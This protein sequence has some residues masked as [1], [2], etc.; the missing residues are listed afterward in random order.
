M[1]FEVLFEVR[2]NL[3]HSVI[4]WWF[5]ILYSGDKSNTIL[6]IPLP[7]NADAS[8][9]FAHSS[10]SDPSLPCPNNQTTTLMHYM[11]TAVPD[12][13]LFCL[14]K[15]FQVSESLALFICSGRYSEQFECHQNNRE[16]KLF[17][18]VAQNK[19][20]FARKGSSQEIASP[21]RGEKC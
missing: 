10:P 1:I 19:G 18:P 15:A 12:R 9:E 21:S 16:Q 11:Q 20:H 8:F 2:S 6:Y 14:S 3:S 5:W 7:Q 13:F 17:L 4:L